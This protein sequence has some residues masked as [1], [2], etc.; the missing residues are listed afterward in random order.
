MQ[1]PFRIPPKLP[2]QAYE[3][4]GIF[5]PLRSHT[6]RA[7]CREVEC[8]AMQRGW[9]TRVDTS[10]ALGARQANYIRLASGRHFNVEQQGDVASFY[11]PAGQQCFAEHRVTL[12]RDP[13]FIKRGGDWRAQTSETVT[14]RPTDWV[15]DFADH[16][17]GIADRRKR[18]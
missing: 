17:Q 12:E 10:S 15:D 13:F 6:R 1:E 8:G 4:Y 11:F 5:R 3:T 2:V 16:Q 18:G 9:V 14:M 7:T